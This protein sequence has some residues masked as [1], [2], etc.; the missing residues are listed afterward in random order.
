MRP[1]D[2]FA[3]NSVYFDVELFHSA[4]RALFLYASI[5]EVLNVILFCI[6]FVISEACIFNFSLSGLNKIELAFI[7]NMKFYSVVLTNV[8]LQK[9]M[10]STFVKLEHD[11][12]NLDTYLPLQSSLDP[13]STRKYLVES[14]PVGWNRVDEEFTTIILYCISCIYP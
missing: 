11:K 10:R 4:R 8:N 13:P 5:G 14:S 3:T 6:L 9:A 7:T 1:V 12:F 2:K